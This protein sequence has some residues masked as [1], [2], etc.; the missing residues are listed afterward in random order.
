MLNP[1]RALT[2]Q[3]LKRVR[4]EQLGWMLS[5]FLHGE[6]G[7]LLATAQIVTTVPWTEAKFS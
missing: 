5:Q 7:A 2:L 4:V 3:E 6:Q 1:P